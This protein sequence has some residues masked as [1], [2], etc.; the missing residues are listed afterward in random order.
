MIRSQDVLQPKDLK[1][2]YRKSL[3]YSDADVEN[4]ASRIFAEAVYKISDKFKSTTVF[5]YVSENVEH[6]YQRV[7]LVSSPTEISR[8]S[9]IYKDVYNGY[10][11]IQQ[12]INGEF[13][14]GSIKHQL[15]VGANYRN[16][17]SSF[18]F[19]DL[20]IFDKVDLTQKFSPLLRQEIDK[21]AVFEPYPTPTQ[22]TIS[23]YVSDMITIVPRLSTM[24]SL[25]VD[26]FNRKK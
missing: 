12:N 23:A 13:N 18:L 25:R 16:L 2:D 19:G 26:H 22:Q 7:V 10:A 21:N 1:L 3:F 8:A 17:S 15:L 11:N 20:Q 9:S 4:S 14:T 6:S 24:L 5:S